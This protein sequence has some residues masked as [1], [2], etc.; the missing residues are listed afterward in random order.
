MRSKK[1]CISGYAET[2]IGLHRAKNEDNF[3]LGVEINDCFSDNLEK[4]INIKKIKNWIC[5]AVFDGI[6]GLEYGEKASYIAADEFR[7][8]FF[9]VNISKPFK[10]IDIMARMTFLM[11]N[12]RIREEIKQDSVSG[13][14]GTVILTNG[15]AFKVF[16]IGDSRAYILKNGFVYQLTRDQTLA[17]MK[18]DMGFYNEY[19]EIPETEKHQLMEYIGYDFTLEGLKPQ[20]SEWISVEKE[21]KILICSDGLYD[22]CDN[23]KIQNIMNKY[24]NS[25]EVVKN[26]VNQS[27]DNG[28]YDNIT[29]IVLVMR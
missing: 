26:L 16:H 5:A 7:K 10:E 27:I 14:T 11:A 8:T 19:D 4:E 21:C 29:G 18:T 17:R 24:D 9:K 25:E 2:N 6:G 13:T 28:G 23:D 22:M 20:E 3:L 12:K 15:T 1:M